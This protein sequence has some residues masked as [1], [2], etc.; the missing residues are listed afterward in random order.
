MKISWINYIIDILIALSFGVLAV[1]GILKYP[2]VIHFFAERDILLP[3]SALSAVHRW[4]GL[5]LTGGALLHLVLHLRWIKNMTV[6]LGKKLAHLFSEKIKRKRQNHPKILPILIGGIFLLGI[7]FVF[8]AMRNT[9]RGTSENGGAGEAPM[10]PATPGRSGE[11]A[12]DVPADIRISIKGFG[13][14]SFDPN[15]VESV[16]PEVFAPGSFSVFDILVHLHKQDKIDLEY[17]FDPELSTHIIDSINGEAGWWYRVVYDGG[18]RENNV[19]RMDLYPY[20]DRTV[21]SLLRAREDELERI[22]TTF[23]EETERKA[24]MRGYGTLIIPEVIIDGTQE[25][26]RFEDVEVTAYNLRTDLF[27][28]GV[29]TAVDVIMSLGDQGKIS[30]DVQWYESVGTAGVVRNYFVQR[31]NEDAMWGR[32]GFV[33]DSGSREF[34]GFSGNHI[35]L[36]PDARVLTAPEYVRF[37]W[38]CI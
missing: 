26:L 28:E 11:P 16:R 1:T 13:A 2:Q 9:G 6:N 18:W 36:P 32:C 30:Y 15:R 17:H 14:F 34:Y 31:I 24:R 22:Y 8:G 33:Y 23:R 20:K 38:I 3:G 27:Q 19:F 10:S 25:T 35:H 7:V 21:V 12:A 29:I 37:F 5:I 4:S